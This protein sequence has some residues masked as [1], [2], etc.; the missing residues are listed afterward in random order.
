MSN[1]IKAPPVKQVEIL[2]LD[3]RYQH[4]RLRSAQAEKQLLNSIIEHGI[5][6]PLQG[7]DVNQGHIL[8]NGFKRYRCALRLKIETVPYQ[9][10]GTD[11]MMGIIELLRISNAK[12]LNILEQ[13]RLIDEL[14]SIFKMRHMDIADL[15]E[16]SVAW[17]SMR[18][19][20]I[21]Q[22]SPL[23]MKK[24]FSGD[25][26][27]YSFMYTIRQF[28][29]MNQ[30]SSPEIDGFVEAVS[31]KKLSTREIEVLAHGYFKGTEA[32]RQQIAT[33]NIHWGLK[34]L[35]ETMTDS[36]DCNAFESKVL[37]DLEITLK[38]MQRVFNNIRDQRLKSASFLAQSNLLTGGMLRVLDGFHKTIKE[39]H[40][41]SR[42]T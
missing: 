6:D 5:R 14:K 19:G 10:L 13:A 27:A 15:L 38:Y 18:A 22:M 32:F 42:Q 16:K 11:E 28:M 21:Q 2:S 12:S 40:D 37:R 34:S 33:G 31:G 17:V 29:R 36:K 1:L 9:S 23:V 3:L 26:P 20:M 8:L 7:V 4:H 30:V 35:R 25:F 24:V 39:F 41:R